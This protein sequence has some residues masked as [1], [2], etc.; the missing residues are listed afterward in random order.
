MREGAG[1][2]RRCEKCRPGADNEQDS[3]GY[4]TEHVRGGSG[5]GDSGRNSG[6]QKDTRKRAQAAT[7]TEAR[8][9]CTCGRRHRHDRV[10]GPSAA[11]RWREGAVHGSYPEKKPGRGTD[12]ARKSGTGKSNIVQL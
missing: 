6:K 9:T 4:T 2:K 10:A 3:S 12:G 8:V 7:G 1:R 11:L 5:V